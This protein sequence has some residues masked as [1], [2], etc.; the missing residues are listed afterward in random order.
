MKSLLL[1]LTFFTRIPLKYPF[2]YKDEDFV[3]GIKYMPVVGLIVG[4]VMWIVSL[5]SIRFDRPV[6]SLLVWIIYLWIT[7]G[8]HIDGLSDSVDG[9]FSNRDR[10]RTLEIMK[11]SRI[12]TFGVLSIFIILSINIVVTSYIDY[13]LLF[14]IPIIGRSCALISASISNYARQNAGMGSPFIDNS[15]K[16]ELII[17]LLAIIIPGV[18]YDY[19]ILLPML[20]CVLFVV[21]VTNYIKKRIGGMTGDTIGLIIEI[22][23]TAFIV[24]VYLFQQIGVW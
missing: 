3:K 8:L 2:E 14:I 22:S 16:K 21:Y 20:C 4:L 9:I 7:G 19:K 12:G 18:I 13:K 15:S 24:F 1:M 6:S 5:S 11:D 17:G 10:E 23:Q